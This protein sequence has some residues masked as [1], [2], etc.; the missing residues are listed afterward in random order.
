MSDPHA[1]DDYPGDGLMLA[2]RAANPIAN[3]SYASSHEPQ[4]VLLLNRILAS[5]QDRHRRWPLS[6]IR[7]TQVPRSRRTNRARGVVLAGT[8][9]VVSIA[10]FTAVLRPWTSRPTPVA[11]SDVAT[12]TAAMV[13]DMATASRAAVAHSGVAQIRFTNVDSDSD[14]VPLGVAAGTARSV[15]S[16]LDVSIATE[17]TVSPGSRAGGRAAD[18]STL[19]IVAGRMYW[20]SAGRWYV[21]PG[22]LSSSFGVL[23]PDTDPRVFLQMLSPSAHFHRVAGSGTLTHLQAGNHDLTIPV[24]LT[25]YNAVAHV[26]SLDVWVDNAGVVH[27]MKFTM[28]LSSSSYS[29]HTSAAPTTI[30]QMINLTFSQLGQPET[31]SAP[32]HATVDSTGFPDIPAAEPPAPCPQSVCAIP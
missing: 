18:A 30:T 20:L 29:M 5:N 13:E 8:L 23:Q 3:A 26:T 11:R 21:A 28:S 22:R 24:Q 12:V 27:Q 19:R 4:A 31:I 9:V 17:F 25:M 32:E 14:G 15:F 1:P 10:G 6:L 16:G 2:L 7:P